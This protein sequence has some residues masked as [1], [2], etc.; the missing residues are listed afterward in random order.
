MPKLP[1]NLIT[2][3]LGALMVNVVGLW[4]VYLISKPTSVVAPSP[5]TIIQDQL[6]SKLT[7][8][9]DP[10][11]VATE[12]DKI[13]ELKEQLDEI[14]G[15]VA[16][17]SANLQ[18]QTITKTITQTASS[19]SAKE[20]V[21]YLG[22]GNTTSREW[23]E[24]GGTKTTIDTAN[25]PAIKNVQFQASLNIVGGEARARFKNKT[26][27]AIFYDSE[28]MHN[29]ST[30]TW[31]SR[32]DLILHNGSNE[33]VIELRSTSGELAQLEGARLRITVK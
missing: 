1:Q 9:A 31:V 8:P 16:T 28:V 7:S 13:T 18:T 22:S 20:Y 12:A 3:L 4:T 17:L 29:S 21:I 6:K 19:N 30:T 14:S 23:I 11:L 15:V 5:T 27:G 10:E 25:Y 33:Y 32:T 2:L 26:T 24:V